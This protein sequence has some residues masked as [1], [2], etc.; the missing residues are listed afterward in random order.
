MSEDKNIPAPQ[1]SPEEISKTT[2]APAVRKTYVTFILD[3]SGSMDCV[4]DAA[5]EFFNSQ[6]DILD[7]KAG[8]LETKVSLIV[9]SDEPEVVVF[10]EPAQNMCRLDREGYIPQGWTALNDAIGMG[11]DRIKKEINDWE[12]DSVSHLFVVVTDGMENCSS[13]Y[14]EAAISAL[15]EELQK[16]GR[17]TFAW[18]AANQDVRKLAD[19]YRIP[20]GNTM[21]FCTSAGGMHA[22]SLHTNDALRTY[23]VSASSG[24][25][26]VQNF[27]DADGKSSSGH[28]DI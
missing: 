25:R 16:T 9:F 6:V 12:D 19:R 3:R 24:A 21:A 27:Y 26:S 17:W 7:E 2:S 20:V 8:Q 10:N 5:I 13:H 22:A 1:E 28:I 14:D 23:Y 15:M 11:I 4:R 18:M